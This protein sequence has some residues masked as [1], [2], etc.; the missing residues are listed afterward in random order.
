ME[1]QAYVQAEERRRQAEEYYRASR[2]ACGR[3]WG[4]E[5][6][7]LRRGQLPA[8]RLP[9]LT[10]HG[11]N[12]CG[13]KL[14]NRLWRDHFIDYTDETGCAAQG[15]R[16]YWTR[17]RDLQVGAQMHWGTVDRAFNL[18]IPHVTK[19]GTYQL[20]PYGQTRTN[21]ESSFKENTRHPTWYVSAGVQV[22]VSRFDTA[23]RVASGTFQG[24]L[25]RSDALDTKIPLQ[26]GRFDVKF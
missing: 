6:S 2:A 21:D 25:Y 5:D 8:L 13:F 15:A 16:G 17:S 9:A 10:R 19:P 24:H 23:A 7:L 18:V 20:A 26:Q 1:R 11:A 14:G 12:S 4:G 3:R 22:R